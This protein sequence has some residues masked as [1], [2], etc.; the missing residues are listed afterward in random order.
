MTQVTQSD[1]D[2]WRKAWRVRFH[3]VRDGWSWAVVDCHDSRPGRE[4]IVALRRT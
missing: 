4:H 3:A 2:W 1:W